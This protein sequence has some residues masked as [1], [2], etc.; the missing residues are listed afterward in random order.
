M[1]LPELKTRYTSIKLVVITV[2]LAGLLSGCSTSIKEWGYYAEPSKES[3]REALQKGG[4]SGEIWSLKLRD[5]SSIELPKSVRPCCAFGND[6]KVKVGSVQVPF[7]EQANTLD[8]DGLGVHAFDSGILTYQQNKL[9]GRPEFE[10]NGLIYTRR[11]GFIDIAHVRD[12]ADLT[13]ALFFKIFP[14]LGNDH[15]IELSPELGFRTIVFQ[16]VDVSHLTS[17]RRWLLAAN[18]SA[19]LAYQLAE[20]HEIAQWHGYRSFVP[21][22]EELSAYSP[23]DVYSNMLGA[24]LAKALIIRN[25]AQNRTMFNQNMTLWIKAAM[26]ELEPVEK[27]QT[28][29]LLDAV[30]GSWWKSDVAMPGKFMVLKRNYALGTTQHPFLV[31]AQQ[32]GLLSKRWAEVKS[33][34]EK[35]VTPLELT[36]PDSLYGFE[37]DQIAQVRLYVDKQY[38]A[39]FQHIPE[40]LW[41]DN[42]IIPVNFS[43]IAGYDKVED[44]KALSQLKRQ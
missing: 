39:S 24:R 4:G 27:H 23:E 10:H 44:D 33:L 25:I 40:Y 12:T 32:A 28:Q 13:I 43:V 7:Y 15:V 30:D 11:G 21:W 31:S 6:Q 37:L 42:P 16:K 26:K 17:R 29:A 22:S 9:T 18:L 2:A 14:E 34:Y 36:L 5:G 20:A 3:V 8:L 38:Q 19:R 35:P 1:I 41:K